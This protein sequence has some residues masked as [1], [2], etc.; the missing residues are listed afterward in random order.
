VIIPI[1][2]TA[3]LDA[4]IE[5]TLKE[6]GLKV[7]SE[8]ECL[9]MLLA[10]ENETLVSHTLTLIGLLN[11]SRYTSHVCNLVNNSNPVIR[12]KAEYTLSSLG[13]I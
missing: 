4:L 8:Y 12:E 5:K 10:D 6:L 9:I 11:D 13:V 1:V 2:E 7:P 3:L